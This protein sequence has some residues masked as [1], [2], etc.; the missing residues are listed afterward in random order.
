MDNIS[1]SKLDE[2]SESDC[3]QTL[4][5]D[6]N[7]FKDSSFLSALQKPNLNSVVNGLLNGDTQLLPNATDGTLIIPRPKI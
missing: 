1:I 6:T 4:K 3:S 7:P 5:I 2:D